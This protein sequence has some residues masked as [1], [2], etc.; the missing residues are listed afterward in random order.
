MEEVEEEPPQDQDTQE[1]EEDTV[2]ETAE[3]TQETTEAAEEEDSVR[4]AVAVETVTADAADGNT[5]RLKDF[6]NLN[7]VRK[8]NA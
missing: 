7:T 6:R 4:I 1:E 2:E 8:S 5:V 3:E